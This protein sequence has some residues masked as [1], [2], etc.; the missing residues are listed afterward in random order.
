MRFAIHLI[1][2]TMSGFLL[3]GNP[4]A[5][6]PPDL[7]VQEVWRHAATDRLLGLSGMTVGFINDNN[8]PDIIV[9]GG[10]ADPWK[11]VWLAYE[12]DDVREEY[13]QIWAGNDRLS[14]VGRVQAFDLENN[15]RHELFVARENG[16]IEVFTALASQPE[17]VIKAPPL[18]GWTLELLHADLDNDSVEELVLCYESG[19][20]TFQNGKMVH[21]FELPYSFRCA[22]GNVDDD[23]EN[24]FVTTDNGI[25][26]YEVNGSEIK[27]EHDL[28]QVAGNANHILLHNLD[29]DPQL[30][31][32]LGMTSGTSTI[33]GVD[34]QTQTELWSHGLFGGTSSM[35]LANM[36]SDSDLE[37][38]YE[39]S[40]DIIALNLED[41]S[42]AFDL[43]L[44]HSSAYGL[45]VGDFDGDSNDELFYS[46][47]GGSHNNYLKSFDLTDQEQ[48]WSSGQFYARVGSVQIV[49]FDHDP[50]NGFELQ[51]VTKTEISR[52]EPHSRARVY[53][54]KTNSLSWIQ[55]PNS[56]PID[57][58][59][60]DQ[61]RD[62]KLF[63]SETG[64]RYFLISYDDSREA[65]I[66]YFDT[67]TGF[68]DLLITE[69]ET[70][71]FETLLIEDIDQDGETELVAGSRICSSGDIVVLRA[72]NAENTMPEWSIDDLRSQYAAS[73]VWD[74][75]TADIDGDSD[76]EIAALIGKVLLVSHN[77][78]QI[79]AT[80][81]DNYTAISRY[82]GPP[83]SDLN[84]IYAA[85]EG[86]IYK[87]GINGTATQQNLQPL[88]SEIRGFRVA[89]T[90]GFG[91]VAIVLGDRR[92]RLY[93]MNN[94]DLMFESME[95]GEFRIG[96]KN[97][98]VRRTHT[99]DLSA[100][101][102]TRH[103]IYYFL[104]NPD[105]L[106]GSSFE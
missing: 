101:V 85:R 6:E 93:S 51:A 48:E 89:R 15:G 1:L 64:K 24:E 73:S 87:I 44:E 41:R 20:R 38:V 76:L 59:S 80:P 27:L 75:A 57:S 36:D 66:S 42:H 92:M 40:G 63:N 4:L 2:A 82:L 28:R 79:A 53:N 86:N 29:E 83:F 13:V 25:V 14:K 91:D 30:E 97:I 67:N 18:P 50:T 78:I 60:D 69:E 17:Y 39:K 106:L 68:I 45:L 96:D 19:V 100:V 74:L 49:D 99:G 55:P 46:D 22:I 62:F 3:S 31:L 21:D 12:Y 7:V 54:P 47:G 81:E 35:I 65:E 32:L 104:I 98:D 90:S 58:F 102:S 94:W 5:G 9:T 84:G 37:L 77:G 71:S 33:V 95:L 43:E 105:F 52:V 103:H 10:S 34:V 16:D 56:L 61:I 26:I 88:A 72:F 11:P 23:P 70:C 8:R